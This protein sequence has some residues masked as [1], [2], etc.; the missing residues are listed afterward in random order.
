M[1]ETEE[2][3]RARRFANLQA[4]KPEPGEILQAPEGQVSRMIVDRSRGETSIYT[5]AIIDKEAMGWVLVYAHYGLRVMLDRAD[6]EKFL[7]RCYGGNYEIERLLVIRQ[8]SK[9]T[10]LIA[11]LIDDE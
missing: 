5:T 10:A 1:A 7:A 4:N 8:N 2:L 11:R 6:H 3:D 9:G